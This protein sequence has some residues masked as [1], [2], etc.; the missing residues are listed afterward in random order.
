MLV[1]DEIVFLNQ[2]KEIENMKKN[3]M[4]I[5]EQKNTKPELKKK[6]SLDW[7]TNGDDKGRN[8]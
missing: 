8:H 1:I 6:K 7:L 2:Q 3:Q 5:L 4:E